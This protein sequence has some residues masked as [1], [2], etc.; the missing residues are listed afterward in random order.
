MDITSNRVALVV[1]I[2]AGAG[3]LTAGLPM[4]NG[5]SS[6]TELQRPVTLGGKP[7]TAD[8]NSASIHVGPTVCTM[9]W[10]F[11]RIFSAIGE[12][13]QD[14]ISL[15][16]LSDMAGH[17]W[18]ETERP[19]LLHDPRLRHLFGRDATYSG[20]SPRLSL[21]ELMLVRHAEQSGV[22]SV[23]GGVHRIAQALANRA[24][25]KAVMLRYES[26][27]AEIRTQGGPVAGVALESA[28]FVSA[29]VVISNRD[30]LLFRQGCVSKPFNGQRRKC[31]HNNAR[32]PRSQSLLRQNQ[33]ASR[34]IVTT[35]F[36]LTTISA[37]SL[38]FA[39]TGAYQA[40]RRC[41]FAHRIAA[42]F[43]RLMWNESGCL[44]S[45][46][47]L[48]LATR[49]RVQIPKWSALKLQLLRYLN[50]MARTSSATQRWPFDQR[51]LTLHTASPARAGRV[52]GEHHTDG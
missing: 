14:A 45:W 35:Y 26:R 13:L 36:F 41:M 38:T 30:A 44:A 9:R 49:V 34:C 10:V 51:R 40:H 6:L 42:T 8:V 16:P 46:M 29:D 15:K 25:A 18:S 21:A 5:V 20:G 47:L 1:V 28:E 50:N 32:A 12:Q 24:T 2:G 33:K 39:S 31:R 4:T 37:S 43:S 19:E 52:T 48:L 7:G 11:E 23:D 3:G 22:W 17:S 27:V